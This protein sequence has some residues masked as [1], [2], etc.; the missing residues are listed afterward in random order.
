MEKNIPVGQSSKLLMSPSSI[1]VNITLAT[2]ASR[3]QPGATS[4]TSAWRCLKIA[5]K[6]V[7]DYKIDYDYLLVSG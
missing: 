5:G 3:R 1:W 4:E 2:K 7:H 6:I